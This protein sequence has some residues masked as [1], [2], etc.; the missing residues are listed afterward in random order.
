MDLNKV[1][2]VNHS[3]LRRLDDM[4]TA[5]AVKVRG[6]SGGHG[7]G[8][9]VGD[10]VGEPGHEIGTKNPMS[11]K[12]NVNDCSSPTTPGPNVVRYHA[13]L[14]NPPCPPADFCDNTTSEDSNT[15]E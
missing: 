7:G 6:D 13:V 8:H 9:G 11:S 14:A 2:D 3:L 15:F 1:R 4:T 5:T 12:R 10:D